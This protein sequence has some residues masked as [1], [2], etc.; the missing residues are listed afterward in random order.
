MMYNPHGARKRLMVVV[1]GMIGSGK[2]M[3]AMRLVNRYG[4]IRV[5]AGAV[6]RSVVGGPAG[7]MRLTFQ[8]AFETWLE[9]NG[10]SVFADAL[11]QQCHGARDVVIDGLRVAKTFEFL[12]QRFG[13]HTEII[14]VVCKKDLAFQRQSARSRSDMRLMDEAEFDQAIRHK[15]EQQVRPLIERADHIIVNNGDVVN[16]YSAVDRIAGA[17]ERLDGIR[18]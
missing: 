3:V 12:R 2:T 11:L 16:L 8:D 1:V 14:H 9:G 6:A 7:E 13:G 17:F 4:F 5:S 10:E 18:R 15:V